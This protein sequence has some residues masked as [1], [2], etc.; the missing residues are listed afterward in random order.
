MLSKEFHR[1][2]YVKTA[3]WEQ[4]QLGLNRTRE[5]HKYVVLRLFFCLCDLV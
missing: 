2:L 4:T 5:I 1:V 3:H